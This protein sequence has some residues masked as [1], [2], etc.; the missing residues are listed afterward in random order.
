MK[1]Q[2]GVALS[3]WFFDTPL[4]FVCMLITPEEVK[5]D[6]MQRQLSD[7]SKVRRHSLRSFDLLPLHF[8][9]SL[10][11]SLPCHLHDLILLA[12]LCYSLSGQVRF[13]ANRGN[14]D[15]HNLHLALSSYL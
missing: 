11:F 13:S 2:G 6:A 4:A 9:L 8:S 12:S 14:L 7:A 10:H 1:Q 15:R 5:P 3:F